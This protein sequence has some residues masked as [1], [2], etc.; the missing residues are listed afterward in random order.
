M[1]CNELPTIVFLLVISA[2][3]FG[4]SNAAQQIV[5]ERAIYRR[6][7]MVNLRLDAYLLSK[8]VPLVVVGA[9]QSVLM[10]ALMALCEESVRAIEMVAAAVLLAT[11]CGASMGLIISALASNPDKAMSIVPLS[12]IPQIILAGVLGPLPE[13]NAP[14][15]W[16][17]YAVAARWANQAGEVGLLQEATIDANLVQNRTWTRPLW[18]LYPDYDFNEVESQQRFLA[19]HIDKQVVRHEWW[20]LDEVVLAGFLLGQ[21]LLTTGILRS[22]DVL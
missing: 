1:V 7:R 10:L 13:M 14:T 3:W 22:Q 17:S 15:R 19:D 20:L 18:N 16:L 2:L 12:L 21:L 8:F 11:W 5:K 9:I 6:E 4:C